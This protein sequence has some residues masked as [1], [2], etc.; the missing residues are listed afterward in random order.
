GSGKLKT[1]AASSFGGK[2]T[3]PQEAGVMRRNALKMA[4]MVGGTDYFDR[5]TAFYE[6]TNNLGPDPN[7]VT[8]EGGTE[9][10]TLKY[11]GAMGRALVD[12]NPN[13]QGVNDLRDRLQFHPD[14]LKDPM[15]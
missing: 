15:P 4:G 8:G 14:S 11:T 10:T 6:N 12:L 13:A 5:M 2:A 3:P 7:R 9:K 1:L